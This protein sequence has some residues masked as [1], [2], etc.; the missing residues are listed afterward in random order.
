MRHLANAAEIIAIPVAVAIGC[1]LPSVLMLALDSAVPIA[2]WL[3]FPL[4]VS[5]VRQAVRYVVGHVA[6]LQKESVHL[7]SHWWAL[8]VVYAVPFICSVLAHG[9]MLWNLIT[10]HD[11]QKEMTRATIKFIEIDIAFIALT[12][13][14]WLLVEAGWRVVV[15][16]IVVSIFL[17]PGAGVC[18]GWVWRENAVD[19]DRSVKVVA[20]GARNSGESSEDTPL[21]R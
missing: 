11:D 14:Y 19:P 13:L 18:V 4:W 7:E 6:A 12:V 9:F 8:A 1:V 3:F 10:Q 15:I 5:L 21:L 20:V 16:M 2:V 17:G